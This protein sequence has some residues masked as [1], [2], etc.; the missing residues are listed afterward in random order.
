MYVTTYNEV[1]EEINNPLYLL[2]SFLDYFQSTET[3]K[4][5]IIYTMKSLKANVNQ[6]TEEIE[7]KINNNS[8]DL[9]EHMIQACNDPEILL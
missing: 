8:A 5:V 7:K 4:K 3:L 6:K 2:F 1:M 9:L